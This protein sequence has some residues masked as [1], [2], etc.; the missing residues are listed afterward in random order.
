M[1]CPR[2]RAPQSPKRR[3]AGGGNRGARSWCLHHEPLADANCEFRTD[4][5]PDQRR[6]APF[7]LHA[8]QRQVDQFRRRA[9]VGEVP[10]GAHRPTHR[11]VQALDRV[12][13]VDRPA[14]RLREREERHHLL[15]GATPP[16]RDRG[17]LLT[18]GTGLERV[19]GFL[20]QHWRRSAPPFIRVAILHRPDAGMPSCGDRE[21]T[22]VIR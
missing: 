12:G 2:A 21:H 19:Q 11:A 9:V 20:G 3:W 22:T 6:R 5:V 10:P 14:D 4:L 13:C 15:P 1:A 16:A 18:P 7:S 8:A 17:V